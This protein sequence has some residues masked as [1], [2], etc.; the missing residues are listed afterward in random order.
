[1]RKYRVTLRDVVYMEKVIEVEATSNAAAV[2]LAKGLQDEPE[3]YWTTTS[4]RARPTLV[5]RLPIDASV[6]KE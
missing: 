3:Y 2:Y 4:I 1:M 6:T 5:K